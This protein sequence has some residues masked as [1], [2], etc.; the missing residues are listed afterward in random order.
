MK[1]TLNFCGLLR[2]PKLYLIHWI[3]I[4]QFIDAKENYRC[5][6]CNRSVSISCFINFLLGFSGNFLLL[7][8]FLAENFGRA[9]NLN[10]CFVLQYITLKIRLFLEIRFNILKLILFWIM[11]EFIE[12]FQWKTFASYQFTC[13]ELWT[14]SEFEWFFRFPVSYPE[15][16]ILVNIRFIIDFLKYLI[17]LQCEFSPLVSII[18]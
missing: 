8:N 7:S 17:L 6:N 15:H 12:M 16:K 11:K 18:W 5:M 2:K 4:V 10:G 1:I 14:R 9:Q 13:W 3:Q